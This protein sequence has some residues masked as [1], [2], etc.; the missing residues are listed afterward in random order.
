MFYLFQLRK[1][2]SIKFLHQWRKVGDDWVIQN[3][4]SSVCTA[5]YRGRG[6]KEKNVLDFILLDLM[7]RFLRNHQGNESMNE[8]NEIPILSNT[9]LHD[10]D[11]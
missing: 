11:V 7:Q 9:K 8:M 10:Y 4:G 6:V 3:A 2:P 5:T 1:E